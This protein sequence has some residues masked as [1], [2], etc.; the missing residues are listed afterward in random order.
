MSVLLYVPWMS[1]VIKCWNEA[2]A[3]VWW[4]YSSKVHTE[5]LLKC[6]GH[7]FLYLKMSVLRYVPWMSTVIKCWN[8]ALS[9]IWWW[10]L[11]KV[12]TE[13]LLYHRFLHLKMPVLWYVPWMRT[14][15][16][17]AI[18]LHFN[19]WGIGVLMKWTKCARFSSVCAA[20]LRYVCR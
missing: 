4:R 12:Y 10:Y 11:S 16:R 3:L 8:E 9:L 17:W 5:A 15:I 2:L 6:F 20:I 13:A 19:I 18:V 1:T 7:R 14:V